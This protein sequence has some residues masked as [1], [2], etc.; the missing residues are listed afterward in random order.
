MC[1]LRETVVVVPDHRLSADWA[2]CRSG[3]QCVVFVREG[4]Q[5]LLDT[6]CELGHE[7]CPIWQAVAEQLP[8]LA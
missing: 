3:G 4:S 7:A 6:Y 5:G 1:N 8:A 2:A